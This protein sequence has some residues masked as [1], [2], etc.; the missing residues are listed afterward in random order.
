MKKIF[1]SGN[2]IVFDINGTELDYPKSLCYFFT[3]RDYIRVRKTF[4]GEFRIFK[5]E[6]A[7]GSWF[8]KNGTTPFTEQSLLEFLRINT[9]AI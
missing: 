8:E 2:Y 7:R 1:I 4:G 6:V 5:A 3:D 9:A